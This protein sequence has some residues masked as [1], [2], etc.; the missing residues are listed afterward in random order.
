MTSDVNPITAFSFSSFMCTECSR[1]SITMKQAF[2]DKTNER[3]QD[4]W[5]WQI[6]RIIL[7]F[8]IKSIVVNDVTNTALIRCV[9][10]GHRCAEHC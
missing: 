1:S 3:S 5:S 9:E 7:M 6:F 10:G 8:D 2:F 4:G